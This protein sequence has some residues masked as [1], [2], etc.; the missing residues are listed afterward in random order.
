MDH[1]L[2]LLLW[3]AAVVALL[4]LV[5][6]F[7]QQ[8]RTVLLSFDVEPVDTP[9]SIAF[10]TS[11]LDQYGANATFF[12]TGQYAEQHPDIV[13]NLSAKY[14]VACHTMTHPRLPE[15]NGTALRWELAACKELVENLT[16]TTVRG[17]R[18]PYNLIDERAFALLKELNYTYDASAFENY[19][20]FYPQPS[21]TEIP[22][23]SLGPI[24]LEDYPLV[25]LLHLGDLGYFLMRQDRDAREAF[26]LHP[27]H[28]FAHRG[29]FQYLVSSY[30]DDDVRFL[31][32]SQAAS[33]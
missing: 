33:G 31:T 26:D 17:F 4:L 25:S 27:H 21:I 28:V 19:A 20:W 22:T 18:A 11:T 30:A 5:S 10:I 16:N 23:S 15:I 1:R 24:P 2:K 7:R 6:L 9:A 13:R 29:A 14:E 8:T 32:Y 3:V 12:V